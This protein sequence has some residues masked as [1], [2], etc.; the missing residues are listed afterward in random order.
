MRFATIIIL[1][2]AV[3][4]PAKAATISYE[5]TNIVNN[6]WQYSYSVYNNSLANDIDEFSI[7]FD[8]NFF[9]NLTISNVPLNWDPLLIQPDSFLPDDGYF[10]ALALGAGIAP[11]STLG[12][13]II[14]FDYLFSGPPGNQ[15]FEIRDAISFDLLES[16]N[17][18]LTG[19]SIPE[20][21][22]VWLALIGMFSILRLLS[23]KSGK[24][25]PFIAN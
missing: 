25:S 18:V 9:E 20:P 2:F 17:T 12:G 1:L 16:G 22:T 23:A 6:R 8:V 11:G 21:N 19:A 13:F 3:I 10:D 24:T 15:Y 5:I 4:H 7:F 14:E